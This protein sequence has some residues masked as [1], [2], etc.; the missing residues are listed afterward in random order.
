[1]EEIIKKAIQA[2][3]KYSELTPNEKK[4]FFSWGVNSTNGFWI[5]WTEKYHK[6][7]EDKFSEEWIRM[8]WQ[9][10]FTDVSFWE[11]LGKACGWSNTTTD[12][13]PN[14]SCS[15]CEHYRSELPEWKYMARKFFQLIF[16][17]GFEATIKYFKAY[18]DK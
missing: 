16:D 12:G 11:S 17:N 13:C 2:G 4:A 9:E 10:V 8:S 3:W 6:N 5:K 15:F 7:L 18:T 1:M 14:D